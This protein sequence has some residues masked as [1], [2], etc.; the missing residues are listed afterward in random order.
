MTVLLICSPLAYRQ[1][2]YCFRLFK[3]NTADDAQHCASFDGQRVSSSQASTT[4]QFTAADDSIYD[5]M[6]AWGVN[7]GQYYNGSYQC[8]VYGNRTATEI[9]GISDDGNLPLCWYNPPANK[10]AYHWATSGG[11]GGVPTFQV[12]NC[13]NFNDSNPA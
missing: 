3:D 13:V 11:K 10:C 2:N 7:L 9:L 5:K 1:N 12:A 8:A 6:Q 4:C